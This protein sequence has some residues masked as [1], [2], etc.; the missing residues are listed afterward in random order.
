MMHSELLK[1]VAS[2]KRTTAKEL[3]VI[4]DMLDIQSEVLLKASELTKAKEDG[5]DSVAEEL[6]IVA[7]ESAQTLVQFVLDNVIL[8]A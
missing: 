5:N 7:E 8:P 3:R 2:S 4:A 1:V 6:R